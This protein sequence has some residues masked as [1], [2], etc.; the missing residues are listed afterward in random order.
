MKPIIGCEVYVAPRAMSD[1]VHGIDNESYHLVLLCKDMEG[2]A[3]LSTLV[4]EGFLHGFYGKPRVDLQL[5]RQHAGGLIALSACLG[6]K[7]PK[8]LA[9]GNYKGA[10][11]TALR[12]AE[13]FGPEHFYI[14]IQDHGLAE[15]RTMLPMLVDLAKDCD[16]PLVATNDCHYLRRRD[17]NAQAVLMCIQTNSSRT[18]AR[19]KCAEQLPVLLR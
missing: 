15:Q 2:Y 4:S 9:K 5:L 13:I 7:I 6:G 19:I 18:T 17:A 1:R 8:Q 11:E 14:E 16:L 3:N 12:Y 10:K